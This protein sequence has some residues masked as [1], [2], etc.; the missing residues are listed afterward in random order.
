MTKN[1]TLGRIWQQRI[2]SPKKELSFEVIVVYYKKVVFTRINVWLIWFYHCQQLWNIDNR[3]IS[4]DGVVYRSSKFT[5]RLVTRSP[6][7]TLTFLDHPSD[8]VTFPPPGRAAKKG[9]P[10]KAKDLLLLLFSDFFRSYIN[11]IP[12]ERSAGQPRFITLS[13]MLWPVW[14]SHWCK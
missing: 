2:K 11:C 7:G 1:I 9:W 6:R 10:E 3:I 12:A 5:P 13:L 4:F 8:T 14:L